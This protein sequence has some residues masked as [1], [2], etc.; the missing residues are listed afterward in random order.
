MEIKN[1]ADNLNKV[2]NFS[3]IIFVHSFYTSEEYF[4]RSWIMYFTKKLLIILALI[5]KACLLVHR[6]F[7]DCTLWSGIISLYKLDFFTYCIY[8]INCMLLSRPVFHSAYCYFNDTV[9]N[10]GW[11]PRMNPVQKYPL[12]LRCRR[13]E[14]ATRPGIVIDPSQLRNWMHV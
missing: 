1:I 8:K 5:L 9:Y 3:K 2:Q 14:V 12:T 13:L 6:V 10:I 7:T 11:I 4:N